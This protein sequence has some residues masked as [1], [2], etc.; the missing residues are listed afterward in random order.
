MQIIFTPKYLIDDNYPFILPYSDNNYY[1]II[2]KNNGLK[3][4]KENGTIELKNHNFGYSK[5]TIYCVDKLNNS[6]LFHSHEF[7]FI[8]NYSTINNINIK[9]FES[10]SYND[11]YFG[12][13]AL[14]TNFGIYGISSNKLTFLKK[15]NNQNSFAYYNYNIENIEKMSCK[16]LEGFNIICSIIFNK[17]IQIY[18][19]SY[20]KDKNNN[21]HSF[22][23]EAVGPSEYINL[24]LYDT[25]L[26]NTKILCKQSKE[27]DTN[28]TC[29]FFE[30][31]FN[32]IDNP[33]TGNFNNLGQQSL[34]FIPDSNDFSE[35]DCCFSAFNDEYLFCCGI[36]DFII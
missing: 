34:T 13:I 33:N 21:F 11:V 23:Y 6:Y 26:V 28:V 15:E 16:C 25:T 22:N 35:K 19:I 36:K 12:S 30:I 5:E 4:N 7:Y 18:A 27:I 9:V 29:H 17:H 3:I 31:T 14:S 10:H 2:T 1:Y 24:A 20:S 32:N 8:T